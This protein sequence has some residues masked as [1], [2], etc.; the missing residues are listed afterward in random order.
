M[1]L[2]TYPACAPY[3]MSQSSSLDIVKESP[4]VKGESFGETR[5]LLSTWHQKLSVSSKSSKT[6]SHVEPSQDTLKSAFLI[7]LKIPLFLLRFLVLY[8]SFFKRIVQ[9]L[10]LKLEVKQITLVSKTINQVTC[11]RKMAEFGRQWQRIKCWV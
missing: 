3:P 4:G 1:L 5:K 11:Y 7:L 2:D 8:H 9:H 10:S 6:F